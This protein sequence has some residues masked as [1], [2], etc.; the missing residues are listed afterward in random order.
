MSLQLTDEI[1]GIIKLAADSLKGASRRL[2]MASV[3]TQI[4]RGGQRR[5]SEELG[6]NRDV[7]RKGERELR[8][9]VVCVD[10]FNMRGRKRLED[11]NPKLDRDI[12]EIAES[13]SQTDPTFRTTQLYRR[14]TAGE[15]RRQLLEERGYGIDEVPS[16][17]SLRR[18]LTE[19]GFAPR[20]VAKSKPK[21]KIKETDAIFDEVRKVNGE[22]DA[23]P[24]TVRISLDTKAVVA[25]G[26]LSRGGKSRQGEQAGDHDFE[27][28]QKLTPF[29]LYRPDT[30]QTWLFFTSGNV[31]ADFMVD[32]LDEIWPDLKKTVI[33]HIPW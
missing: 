32:R 2:F 14:L 8:S 16:E 17:R 29:G 5:A 10:A 25:I 20:K 13:A 31:T 19:K 1:K 6:W 9:G 30:N 28:E 3:V 23:D 18:K 24:G 22:A 21:R 26:D 27:P 33:L 12:R 4:G 11:H 15:V 7:I